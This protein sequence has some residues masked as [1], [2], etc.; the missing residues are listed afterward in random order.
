MLFFI[1]HFRSWVAEVGFFIFFFFF[2]ICTSF[3]SIYTYVERDGISKSW[4]EVYLSDHRAPG[5]SA[6]PQSWSSRHTVDPWSSHPAGLKTGWGSLLH[7]GSLDLFL[8]FSVLSCLPVVFVFLAYLPESASGS[9]ES[10]LN[11]STAVY[12]TLQSGGSSWRAGWVRL[13][14]AGPVCKWLL[15]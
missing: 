10:A 2:L 11:C 1:L 9:R 8:I 14:Y 15:I 4:G 12:W 3:W 7:P 5:C 6:S 13:E